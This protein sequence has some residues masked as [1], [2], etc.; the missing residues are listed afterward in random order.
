MNLQGFDLLP[1]RITWMLAYRYWPTL[2]RPRMGIA[3]SLLHVR[4]RVKARCWPLGCRRTLKQLESPPRA[5]LGMDSVDLDQPAEVFDAF[6]AGGRARDTR[7]QPELRLADEIV[8]DQSV[9]VNVQSI[10]NRYADVISVQMPEELDVD[11]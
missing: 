1:L 7:E 5:I 10:V 2:S 3:S 11:A 4:L 6:A 8:R 9:P